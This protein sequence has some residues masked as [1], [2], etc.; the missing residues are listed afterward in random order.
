M[1]SL[2]DKGVVKIGGWD[3]VTNTIE[4]TS[5][6]ISSLTQAVN[7]DMDNFGKM[8][9][10][11]GSSL[12]VSLVG[13]RNLWAGTLFPYMLVAQGANLIALDVNMSQTA[14]STTLDGNGPVSYC[15]I[16]GTVY[17]T[18]GTSVGLITPD[19]VR[20]PI[21]TENPPVQPL[22]A[23]STLGGLD[24]GNYQV[25]ST[26]VDALGRESGTSIAAQITVPAGGGI[27]LTFLNAPADIVSTRVYVTKANG[28][29]LY[30]YTT[31]P[32]AMAGLT[33]QN[34]HL[35]S[36]LAT[37]FAEP[38][39]AGHLIRY[40]NGRLYIAD[41]DRVWFSLPLRYG[42]FRRDVSYM[43]FKG[44]IRM[45]EP[46][47]EAQNSSGFYVSDDA[48]VYYRSGAAPKDFQQAIAYPYPAV[49]GTA[50]RV[51][52]SYLGLEITT[53]V[54][55]WLST[56]G[57]FCIG[58]PGGVVIPF[59]EKYVVASQAQS[60]A[61]IVRDVGGGIRQIVTNLSGIGGP[62]NAAAGVTAVG[63]VERNGVVV[64]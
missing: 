6:P 19:L 47:G 42:Q 27:A 43:K 13:A 3:G 5:L 54:V 28:D 10:R 9:L 1:S 63:R 36:Q 30:L 22:L 15:E 51:P 14:L 48:R 20:H 17:W 58:T 7:V 26:W 29:K 59:S 57:V 32:A 2:N 25:A 61:S 39:P 53:N 24:A 35:E 55:Y 23:L 33:I 18:D 11:Q 37:Q 40:F 12:A 64:Q 31:V 41:K 16:N 46:V 52:G 49:D 50:V 56:N 38:M 8:Q 62:Q 34:G 44:H 21:Y 60:G 45:L 4:E